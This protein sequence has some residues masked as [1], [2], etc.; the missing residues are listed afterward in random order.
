MRL[1][2]L[3]PGTSARAV[4]SKTVANGLCA[5][6]MI[7][8]NFA[9]ITVLEGSADPSGVFQH[10]VGTKCVV[11]WRY[12]VIGVC[13]MDPVKDLSCVFFGWSVGGSFHGGLLHST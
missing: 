13:G 7:S 1:E 5:A 2:K 11:W 4:L 10:R 12:D 6:P 3:F 8:L 9:V